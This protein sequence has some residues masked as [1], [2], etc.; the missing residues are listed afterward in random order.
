MTLANRTQIAR[1]TGAEPYPTGTM[2]DEDAAKVNAA[3][4]AATGGKVPCYA[5]PG[6]RVP[7]KWV[8][9]GSSCVIGRGEA[10]RLLRSVGADI[11][12]VEAA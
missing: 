11:D 10:E 5:T 3:I 1:I 9:V 6:K 12:Q 8:S 7:F 4:V 2:H